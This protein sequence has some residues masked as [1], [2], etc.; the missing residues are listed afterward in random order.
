M[1]N[2]ITAYPSKPQITNFCGMGSGFG[3]FGH[4]D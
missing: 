2:I 3:G 4:D 1:K